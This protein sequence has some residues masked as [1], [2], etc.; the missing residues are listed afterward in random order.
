MIGHSND[1]NF[2][3]GSSP[4]MNRSRG[5]LSVQP[6]QLDLQQLQEGLQ[7]TLD[8]LSASVREGGAQDKSSFNL[9]MTDEEISNGHPNSLDLSEVIDMALAIVAEDAASQDA[10]EAA[11]HDSSVDD[12][13]PAER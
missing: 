13:Q 7:R 6:S 3:L 11:D 8:L 12:D 4:G 5:S 1:S 9:V 10:T 2:Y